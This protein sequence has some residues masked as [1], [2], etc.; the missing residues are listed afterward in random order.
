MARKTS[1][2]TG[3]VILT[4][5]LVLLIIF[6][7]IKQSLLI[8]ATRPN[9]TPTSTTPTKIIYIEKTPEPRMQLPVYPTE[10]PKYPTR[11]NPPNYQQVGVLVSRDLNEGE[12][13]ILPLFG[14]KMISRD[15]W[16]YY[17][18]S[19]QYHM[20]KLTVQYENRDCQ[21]DVGCN[22]I[23]N[24]ELVTVPDYA[25]KVFTARIYK[26]DAPRY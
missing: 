14:R 26:Y 20:Y 1:M 3:I 7:I 13:V 17:V 11:V 15:R 16:E 2:R 5:L 12:P 19:N 9:T 25:N 24:G 18:A 23:F 8:Y 6:V 22:E 21:D 4:S 10:F